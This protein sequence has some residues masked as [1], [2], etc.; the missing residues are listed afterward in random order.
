MEESEAVGPIP[1]KGARGDRE[2]G[3][4]REDDKEDGKQPAPP[5]NGVVEQ[6]GLVAP[7]RVDDVPRPLEAADGDVVVLTEA[8]GDEVIE[9]EAEN[10]EKDQADDASSREAVLA[11]PVAEDQEEEEGEERKE[12]GAFGKARPE[13]ESEKEEED[14]P[15]MPDVEENQFGENEQVQQVEAL[16]VKA[17]GGHPDGD[18]EGEREGGRERP[19]DGGEDRAAGRDVVGGEAGKENAR[20][21]VVDETDA[22]DAHDEAEEI[23]KPRHVGKAHLGNGGDEPPPHRE[24]GGDPGLNAGERRHQRRG[25]ARE[26]PR[27]HRREID[28]K[29]QPHGAQTEEEVEPP[30]PCRV[31]FVGG[32]CSRGVLDHVTISLG[33]WGYSSSTSS[34]DA[35]GAALP[36]PSSAEA[37]DSSPTLRL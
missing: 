30:L 23:Q 34:S 35:A 5:A 19:D 12:I 1:A 28:D 7:H 17:G 32:F 8:T 16:V 27:G 22:E 3:K 4:P 13:E 24:G 36:S 14:K 10:P 2:N 20:R 15:S 18:G 31:V 25:S 33:P 6:V 26:H 29:G 11:E 37:L 9:A 21:N